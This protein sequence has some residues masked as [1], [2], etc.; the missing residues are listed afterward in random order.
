MGTVATLKKRNNDTKRNKNIAILI[1]S[2]HL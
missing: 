1:H 2:F